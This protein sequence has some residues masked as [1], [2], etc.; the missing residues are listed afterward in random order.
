MGLFVFGGTYIITAAIYAAVMGL[1]AE[2]RGRSFKAVS[3][4]LLPPLGIMFAL[5]V[6]FT[7]S[8]VWNDNERAQA[9]VNRE[10]SAL[11]TIIVMSESFSGDT[12]ARLR[13]LIR[14]HI[15]ETITKEWA[16][17]RQGSATLSFTP[18]ALDNALRLTVVLNSNTE[19]QKTAQR[20]MITA[21]ESA[22]D[23]RR[24][25]ILISQSQ[26]N[27]IKWSC[28]LLQAICALVAIAMVHSDNRLA[29]AITMTLFATGIA[30]SVLIILSH[31]RP[32]TGEVAVGPAPLLQVIPDVSSAPA[33]SS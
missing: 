13:E 24:Q 10:A 19:G 25:R 1:A 32:F 7:A 5:F 3:P 8:Q 15:T 20:E 9:A 31:D 33:K 26:V 12:E 2:G 22:L 28:L 11:K 18:P 30:A 6:A 29:A 4:G 27:L 17:L 16:L 23:A 14:D 21:I